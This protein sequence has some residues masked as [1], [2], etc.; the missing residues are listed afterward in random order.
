MRI[1][2]LLVFLCGCAGPEKDP[3]FARGY[4]L[5]Q[6]NDEAGWAIEW[7]RLTNPIGEHAAMSREE[8]AEAIASLVRGWKEGRDAK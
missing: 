5:G 8:R 7:A 2:I 3:Y 4:E 6:R 1:L